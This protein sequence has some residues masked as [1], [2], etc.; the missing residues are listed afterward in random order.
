VGV[1]RGPQPDLGITAY[2]K[3]I[4]RSL[5]HENLILTP[6]ER[7]HKVLRVAEQIKQICA[8]ARRRIV[9][10]SDQPFQPKAM[11][12]SASPLGPL[13]ALEA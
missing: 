10:L 4:D 8:A 7:L 11:R 2:K 3:G 9:V 12:P 1:Q 5:I 6:K 13:D